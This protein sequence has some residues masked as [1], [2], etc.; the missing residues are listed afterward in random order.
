MLNEKQQLFCLEYIKDLN[1]TQAAIRAG[2]S[3]KTAY[4]IGQR[5]LK[6]VEIQ[7]E[8]ERLLSERS[9]RTKIDADWLLTRLAAEA[10][11]DVADLYYDNGRI[12]P[13]HEWPEVWRQGLVT[14]M[15]T[16]AGVITG[17]KVSDRIK[18]LELIGKHIGVQAFKDKVEVSGNVTFTKMLSDITG[19]ND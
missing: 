14:G 1:A 3:E 12:K 4:S 8:T 9:E 13:V 10:M 11:A 7:K 6:H 16:T 5:L 17:L 19:G 2:Y 15:D 18:R